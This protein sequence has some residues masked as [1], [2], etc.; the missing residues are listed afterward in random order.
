MLSNDGRGLL[1]LPFLSY[2][3][4]SLD[5]SHEMLQHRDTVPGLSD[6]GAHLGMICDGS[7]STSLLTHW[8]RDRSRG[9]KLS[10]PFV[11]KR[12]AADTA[13]L[14]GLAD[15]GMILPGLRAD[16]NVIDYDKLALLAPT[17]VHDLPAGGRRLMQ[18]AKGYVATIVAGKITYRDG[19]PTGALPGRLVRGARGATSRGRL[20]A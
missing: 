12:Q 18:R 10:L 20:A 2:G 5:A 9:P 19:N 7:F 4:G 16:L 1:Y 3:Y 14:V 17:T 8:T 6:G 11:V 15:R 13:A